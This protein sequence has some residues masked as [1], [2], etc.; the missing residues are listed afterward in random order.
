MAARGPRRSAG[1]TSCPGA[2]SSAGRS[3][4]PSLPS[5]PLL[6]LDEP[7]GDA[8]REAPARVRV[9]LKSI[10]REIGIT[11]VFVTHDQ[12]EA[13]TMSDRLAVMSSGKVERLG[14]SRC[15][16]ASRRP[17]SSRPPQRVEPH[18]WQVVAGRVTVDVGG[19]ALRRHRARRVRE[20]P[21]HHPARGM[22]PHRASVDAR[23]NRVQLRRDRAVRLPRVTTRVFVSLSGGDRVQ[24]LVANSE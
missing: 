23:E 15:V 20:S 21:S 8:R 11:F 14:V 1:R 7:L 2:S 5:R 24:A 18:A 6:L 22:R 17:L 13:L 3:P 16:R 10:Q 9:E 12:E 19:V 4:E